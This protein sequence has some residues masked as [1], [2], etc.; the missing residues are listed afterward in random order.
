MGGD[1]RAGRIDDLAEV[2]KGQ[3]PAQRPGVVDVEGAPTSV[4]ALH[5]QHPLGPA[6][7]RHP[8]RVRLGMTHPAQRQRHHGGVVDVRVVVVGELEGPAPGGQLGAAQ[9]PVTRAQH[10]LGQQPVCGPHQRR[11]LGRHAGVE[12]RDH[13]QRGVPHRRLARL[14]PTGSI[15]L[16]DEPLDPLQAPAHDRMLERVP[17]QVQSHE[18]VHPRWLDTSPGAVGL[19]T[20]HYPAFGPGQSGTPQGPERTVLVGV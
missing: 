11:I 1:V 20:A 5:P 6:V 3:R 16:D 13:G 4:R 15:L 9:G 14:E 12:Q 18:R 8:A 2:A 10:L 19:L 17:L 7:D